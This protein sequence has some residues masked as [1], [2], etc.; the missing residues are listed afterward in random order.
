MLCHQISGTHCGPWKFNTG[1]IRRDIGGGS[2]WQK[3]FPLLR[4]RKKKKTR[5]SERK[6][7]TVEEGIKEGVTKL[8]ADADL[9][10]KEDGASES[11]SPKCRN[12]EWPARNSVGSKGSRSV[13][14]LG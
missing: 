2:T 3:S 8:W 1:I 4:K 9:S 10:G 11:F 6:V 13:L 5:T 7:G 12:F 14:L